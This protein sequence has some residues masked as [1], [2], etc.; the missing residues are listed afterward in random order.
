MKWSPSRNH[1]TIT[2]TDEAITK[3][4]I[5]PEVAQVRSTWPHLT[6]CH[7]NKSSPTRALIAPLKGDGELASSYNQTAFIR[8]EFLR[9]A[10]LHTTM[11][12][13]ATQSTIELH[14]FSDATQH[15]LTSQKNF[16]N[17]FLR[18]NQRGNPSID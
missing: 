15:T 9:L 16:I 11:V 18:K 1:F 8:V 12:N 3:R 6:S 13:S 4:I 17:N 5:P 7:Q 14:S 2:S 10:S